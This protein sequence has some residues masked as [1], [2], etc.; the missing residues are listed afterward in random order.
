MRRN[1]IALSASDRDRSASLCGE[2]GHRVER[3]AY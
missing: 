2:D 3:H 1:H